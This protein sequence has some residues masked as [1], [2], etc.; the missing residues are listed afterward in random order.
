[1]QDHDAKLR[2]NRRKFISGMAAL[3]AGSMTLP[4]WAQKPSSKTGVVDRKSVV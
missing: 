4:A 2:L 1:M 3:G